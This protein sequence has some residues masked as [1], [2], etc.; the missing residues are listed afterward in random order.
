MVK[1]SQ[2]NPTALLT[3]GSPIPL[4]TVRL[5]S[6]AASSGP[7]KTKSSKSKPKP[8]AKPKSKT[9][10]KELIQIAKLL[11][12]EPKSQDEDEALDGSASSED[13]TS[14]DTYGPQF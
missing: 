10:N 3:Q 7:S 12:A 11:L 14:H 8:K 2:Q 5:G 9:S 6:L 4:T 1:A 13:S